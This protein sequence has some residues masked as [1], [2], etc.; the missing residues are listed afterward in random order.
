MPGANLPRFLGVVKNL[1][2]TRIGLATM[3]HRYV[4]IEL[5]VSGYNVTANKSHIR[6]TLEVY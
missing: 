3:I 1:C 2:L 5:S 4:Y 6:F